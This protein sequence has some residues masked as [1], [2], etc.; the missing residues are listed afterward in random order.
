MGQGTK[1]KNNSS[2]LEF[3]IQKFYNLWGM[4][5]EGGWAAY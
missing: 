1:L 5:G 2:D 3:C 4:G